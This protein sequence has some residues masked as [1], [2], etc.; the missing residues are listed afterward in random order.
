LKAVHLSNPG[1]AFSALFDYLNS[2]R[3]FKKYD[4]VGKGRFPVNQE[5]TLIFWLTDA[6]KFSNINAV[7]DRVFGF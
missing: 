3:I 5:S 6:T 2:K 7:T 1:A 4:V